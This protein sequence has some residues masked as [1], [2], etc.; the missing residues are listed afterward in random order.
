MYYQI[1]TNRLTS[2]IVQDFLFSRGYSWESLGQVVSFVEDDL[3]IEKDLSDK[4]LY[5]RFKTADR[6]HKYYEVLGLEEFFDLF[7]KPEPI[8]VQ[9]NSKCIATVTEDEIIVGCQR[10]PHSVVGKLQSAIDELVS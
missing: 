6:Q 9:L 2:Q 5:R 8:A 3:V 1:Q 10:F 7:Y 4:V